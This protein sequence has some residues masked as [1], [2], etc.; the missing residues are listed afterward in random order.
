MGCVFS[1]FGHPVDFRVGSRPVESLAVERHAGG[2]AGCIARAGYCSGRWIARMAAMAATLA[3]L[4]YENRAK[5]NAAGHGFAPR[6]GDRGCD[7]FR[8]AGFRVRPDRAAVPF[9]A[10]TRAD[11]LRDPATT[12]PD[13]NRENAPT[14]S[15]K[16]QKRRLKL[17]RYH[18]KCTEVFM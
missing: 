17:A 15:G 14:I 1:F 8:H 13:P 12:F 16:S 18:D 10:L 9:P 5:S 6:A 3:T 7:F 2:L 4:R 11:R